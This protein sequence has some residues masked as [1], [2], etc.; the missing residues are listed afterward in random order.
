M[1]EHDGHRFETVQ[2]A[3]QERQFGEAHVRWEV[4]MDGQP[5]LEFSGPFHYRDRDVRKR[6][7]EW[8]EIQK[9]ASRNV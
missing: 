4:R 3:P 8:Y 5:V 7:L 1:F 9:P 2:Y 6:V